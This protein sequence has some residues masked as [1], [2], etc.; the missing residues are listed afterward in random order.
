MSII[1]HDPFAEALLAAGV[2][3]V[4][5]NVTRVVIDA[6]VGHMPV[7]YVERYADERLLEVVPALTG[8]EIR[9]S[10]PRPS[11][12]DL[13]AAEKAGTLTVNDV[14]A[15]K[16]LPPVEWGNERWRRDAVVDEAPDVLLSELRPG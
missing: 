7:I 10:R 11:R 9:E 3:R 16:G 15:S 14:R 4:E 1:S 2:I 13:A 12:Y 8:V 6:K 5:D